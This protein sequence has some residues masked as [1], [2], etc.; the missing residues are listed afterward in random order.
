MIEENEKDRKKHPLYHNDGCGIAENLKM[1]KKYLHD[2]MMIVT[3][4]LERRMGTQPYKKYLHDTM[5]IIAVAQERARLNE[6]NDKYVECK[7]CKCEE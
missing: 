7:I 1:N 5:T 6:R 4:S 3:V 2:T